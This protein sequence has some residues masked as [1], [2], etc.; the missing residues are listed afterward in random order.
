MTV[1]VG[2]MFLSHRLVSYMAVLHN[3]QNRVSMQL[4]LTPVSHSSAMLDQSENVAS[5]SRSKSGCFAAV[6][7]SNL[8]RIAMPEGANI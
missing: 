4:L 2:L 5:L 7:S 6:Q 3:A 8:A 1:N